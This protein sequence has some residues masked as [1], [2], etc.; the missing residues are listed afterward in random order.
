[1]DTHEGNGQDPISLHKYLYANANPVNGRDPSGHDDLAGLTMAMSVGMT[2]TSMSNVLIAGVYSAIYGGFPDAVAF[3]VFF[4]GGS[5]GFP[6]DVGAVGGLEVVYSPRL[7]ETATYLW[8][9]FEPSASAP[10]LTELLHRGF[11]G[12]VGV[13]T[14]WSWNVPDL[15]PERFALFGVSAGGVFFGQ[16]SAMGTSTTMFGYTNDESMAIFGIVGGE[17]KLSESGISET[18]MVTQVAGAE[19]AYGALGATRTSAYV[20]PAAGLAGAVVSSGLTAAWVHYT[21]GK[22]N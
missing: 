9:G 14:S 6:G 4:A 20:N 18:A 11:H 2:I 21:Y 10:D 22:G 19:A 3:G 8:G 15:D 12:E 17:T 13:F 16:E 5:G 7:K 1:M